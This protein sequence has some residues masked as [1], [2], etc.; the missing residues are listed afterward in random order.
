MIEGQ[1]A[2]GIDRA[3]AKFAGV[4]GRRNH[5]RYEE[6]VADH[7]RSL[8]NFLLTL[9]PYPAEA[10]DVLQD[11]NVIL[12]QKSAEYDPSRPFLPWAMRIAQLQAMAHCKKRRR[13]RLLDDQLLEQ[14]A[15]ETIAECDLVDARQQALAAC[16][17]KLPD[18]HRQLVAQRYEPGGCVNEIAGQRGTSPKAI[19]EM[20]R[21]IRKKLQRCI[22]AAVLGDGQP[23]GRGSK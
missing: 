17:R 22:E 23:P 21:R 20:L 11:V 18:E 1:L 6:D 15:A 10:E 14:V 19:S 12:V 3:T 4:D 7:Q 16:L 2:R 13:W 5:R 9:L 8:L